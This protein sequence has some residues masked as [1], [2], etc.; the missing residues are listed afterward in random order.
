MGCE[1][2]GLVKQYLESNGKP[3]ADSFAHKLSEAVT[4]FLSLNQEGINEET[5]RK[6]LEQAMA[7][8]NDEPDIAGAVLEMSGSFPELSQAIQRN[9]DWATEDDFF[10]NDNLSGDEEDV[11]FSD[12]SLPGVDYEELVIEKTYDAIKAVHPDIAL[13]RNLEVLA[14]QI[15]QALATHL[16][17][18]SGDGQIPEGITRFCTWM[19]NMLGELAEESPLRKYYTKVAGVFAASM[20]SASLGKD[21]WKAPEPVN[22]IHIPVT[23]EMLKQVKRPAVAAGDAERWAQAVRTIL[24]QTHSAYTFDHTTASNLIYV[25]DTLTEQG[26]TNANKKRIRGALQEIEKTLQLMDQSDQWEHYCFSSDEERRACKEYYQDLLNHLHLCVTGGTKPK[27]P[28]RP[29][30]EIALSE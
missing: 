12:D 3:V 25:A 28:I 10:P 18:R 20:E 30:L 9:M 23:V 14:F 16:D 17:P 11:F 22:T 15:Q 7:L 26:Y 6:V 8:L 19:Q 21:H 13:H 29:F 24:M 4:I 2:N 1:I 27:K 5:E